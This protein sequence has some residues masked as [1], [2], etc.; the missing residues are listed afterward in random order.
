MTSEIS[1]K[2][3]LSDKMPGQTQSNTEPA[4]R[5][6]S[7]AREFDVTLRTLRF[8]EDKGLLTPKRVGTT[9]LYSDC[10]RIRLKLILFSKQIGF[11]LVEIREILVDYDANKHLKN[12]MASSRV[13]F[14]EKLITLKNQRAEIDEAIQ[15]LSIQ[16]EIDDGIFSE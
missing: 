2:A 6:G 1:F 16:L 13:R 7:L 15:E 9:R 4:Y 3:G 5:I 8:Y 12:P 14:Q 10:D 11:S